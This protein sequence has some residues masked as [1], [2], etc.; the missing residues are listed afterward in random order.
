MSNT[1]STI[2]G[3]WQNGVLE[4]R[5]A[6]GRVVDVQAPVVVNEDFLGVTVDIT[7][8]HVFAAVN[9]GAIARAAGAA[10][11]ARLTTGGA[12]DD[13]AELA[14][15]LNFL[16]S[17]GCSVEVSAATNDI[18]GSGFCIGFSDATGEAADTLAVTYSGTTLTSSATDCAVFFHDPDATTDVIRTVAVKND[19]DGTVTSTGV[20]AV[21]GTFNRYRVDVK[22]NGDV[23]FYLNGNH[24][25]THAAAI[26]TTAPL[27]VYIGVINR[28]G[29]ANTFD[30]DYIRAWAHSR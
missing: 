18:A 13:D 30:V 8:D 11:I 1:L 14:T 24:V 26:T 28:E 23:S 4:F 5:D 27:C 15:P 12:D 29:A 17:K 25:A 16:A 21:N 10:G 6:A 2:E 22:S 3:V 19:V 9:S 20:A 7:N